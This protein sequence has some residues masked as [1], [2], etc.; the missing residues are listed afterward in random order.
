MLARIIAITA[1]ALFALVQPVDASEPKNRTQPPQSK[2]F[3][4][5]GPT[6]QKSFEGALRWEAPQGGETFCL[7]GSYPLIWTGGGSGTVLF[8]LIDYDQWRVVDGGPEGVFDNT[9]KLTWQIPS[10]VEPG[11]YL[12]YVQ[13]EDGTDWRYSGTFRIKNCGCD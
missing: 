9:G 4:L 6:A 8:Q 11:D 3:K 1:A 7:W 12:M 10:S 5:K 13:R 2:G